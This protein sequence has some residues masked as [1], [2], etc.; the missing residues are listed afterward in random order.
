[1]VE[2]SKFDR[3]K[4]F[5]MRHPVH[6]CVRMRT[7]RNDSMCAVLW[8][9]LTLSRTLQYSRWASF[10]AMELLQQL[11][12]VHTVAHRQLPVA[13]GTF[14]SDVPSD[15]CPRLKGRNLLIL[16]VASPG[17]VA[18]RGKDWNYVMVHSRWTS[19]PGAAAARWLI[20]LWLMQ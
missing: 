12:T 17:F 5:F 19:G 11:H 1:V 7:E 9:W 10:I 3:Y 13:D 14:P 6:T 15:F 8:R 2:V 16:S 20:I 18:R 4:E